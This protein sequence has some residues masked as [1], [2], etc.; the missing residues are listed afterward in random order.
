MTHEPYA[1]ES[2]ATLSL[3]EVEPRADAGPRFIEN[4][5]S[6]VSGELRLFVLHHP[7]V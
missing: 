7:P 3:I 4:R 2:V 1:V 6:F 5:R